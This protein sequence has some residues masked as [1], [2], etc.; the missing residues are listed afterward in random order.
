MAM[1]LRRRALTEVALVGLVLLT[2]TRLHAV[3]GTDEAVATRNADAL[4]SMEAWLHLDIELR[5]NRWLVGHPA[6][7]TPSVILYR[8]YYVV[9]LGVLVW[10]FLRHQEVY[11]QVRSTLVVMAALALLVYWAL[12]VSPPRFAQAGISDVI[13]QHDL[14]G[15]HAVHEAGS[16]SAM[17]SLHVGW[18]ALAAY[19]AWR[20]PSPAH[21]RAALLVWLFP[22][23]M[24][25]VVL[26][27]GNHYV[28]DVVGSAVLLLGS[29]AAARLWGHLARAPG[30]RGRGRGPADLPGCP[31]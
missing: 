5:A 27:T 21:G 31:T 29:I 6:L 15:A 25:L 23:A 22:I 19:A 10:V 4:Q 16:F 18:S 1:T 30:R 24:T 12:P 28:L 11:R 26:G 2:F 8:G 17:P 14:F 13:A 7:V 20:S 3:V 9:L